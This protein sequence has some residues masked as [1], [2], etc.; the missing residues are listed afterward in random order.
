MARN[1]KISHSFFF[2]FFFFLAAATSEEQTERKT[3]EGSGFNDSKYLLE[4]N[5]N[6][7]YAADT[8]S[9]CK[10]RSKGE[11]VRKEPVLCV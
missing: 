2:F 7:T 11:R 6:S 8:V 3:D 9:N 5:T 1:Y 10:R 4:E